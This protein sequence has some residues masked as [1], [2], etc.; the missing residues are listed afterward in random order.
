MKKSFYVKN[1]YILLLSLFIFQV[2][3]FAD[4]T[5]QDGYVVKKGDNLYRIAG[6]KEIYDNFKLWPLIY[7]ANCDISIK[8]P[9]DIKQGQV[10]KIRK[11][12]SRKQEL[13]GEYYAY[14]FKN[15][16]TMLFPYDCNYWQDL[17]FDTKSSVVTTPTTK[18]IPKTKTPV[19]I[20]KKSKVSPKKIYII[21]YYGNGNDGGKTAG[22]T[23][24]HGATIKIATNGFI[25]NNYDFIGWNTRKDGSGTKITTGSLYKADD[26]LTLYAQWGTLPD[27]QNYDDV[28][29][30]FNEKI[31]TISFDNKGGDVS[32]CKIYP[33]I[34][35]NTGLKFNRY[36]CDIYGVT[37]NSSSSVV[38]T[39]Y[40]YNKGARDKTPAK[41]KI[42]INGFVVKEPPD[43][44]DYN[45]LEY[46]ID[47]EIDNVIFDNEGGDVTSCTIY[48]NITKNTG[49]MFDEKNCDIYGVAKKTSPPVVYTVQ[50]HNKV[51]KDKTPASIKVKV[52]K[53]FVFFPALTLFGGIEQFNIDDVN[54]IS[55]DSSPDSLGLGFGVTHNLADIWDGDF[56]K[57]VYSTIY[58]GYF[59]GS[60][61]TQEG[62]SKRYWKSSKTSQI[63]IN[64]EKRY[65]LGESKYYLAPSVGIKYKN[66]SAT[67]IT[68]ESNDLE[69][70]VIS[71]PVGANLGYSF[72]SKFSGFIRMAYNLDLSKKITVNDIEPKD[73]TAGSA[74]DLLL[75]VTYTIE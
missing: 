70:T 72:N 4:T 37:N 49:L 6:K 74:L 54:G 67:R 57:G 30:G 41:I 71:M 1:F 66:L 45:D 25:K 34:T 61:Y 50:A 48:P 10:L 38:Y 18:S 31:D 36:N 35:K 44:K 75:G 33:D 40:A 63:G 16:K 46:D 60:Y 69:A 2:V 15:Q 3:S 27:L 14:R 68:Q 32:S 73:V 43:I 26:D 8:N 56:F 51:G 65:F 52:D 7:F 5:L 20:K 59:T 23:K 62:A 47:E 12:I 58:L 29:Y 64:L 28:E 53:G 22:Q 11:N 55:F 19:A 24:L 17:I 21:T 42:D 13:V 9:K 39:V